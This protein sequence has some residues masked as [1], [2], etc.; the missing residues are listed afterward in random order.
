MNFI[1]LA[2]GRGHRMGVNKALML[3]QGEP[4][5][6]FQLRQIAEL[7]LQ[8]ITIVTNPEAEADLQAV[9]ENSAQK[10]QVLSNPH[11][12]KGPFSSLQLAIAATPEAS[13]F[14]SPV[15]VPLKAST[16]KKLHQA[17]L[18]HGH[19]DALIPSYQN[20]KGHPVIIS[21]EFQRVLLK[22]SPDDPQARLDV[23]LKTL[24][25]NKKRTLALED[26]F[27]ALNL[28]TQEDL[29]SIL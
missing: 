10:V 18:Q 6:L 14:V 19:L 7:N 17:W 26:P 25:E 12:D 1:L 4:W 29:A 21:S 22:M 2:G 3:H 5:I 23:A 15:D 28:N 27:I 8:N 16:L 13:S 24:P 11:P 20:Q 9:L